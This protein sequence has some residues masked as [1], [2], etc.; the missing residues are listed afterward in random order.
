MI[1]HCIAKMGPALDGAQGADLAAVGR[2]VTTQATAF[3][4]AIGIHGLAAMPWHID[5][6]AGATEVEAHHL[7]FVASLKYSIYGVDCALL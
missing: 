5:M 2:P 6:D 7:G 1:S 4:K 3:Q